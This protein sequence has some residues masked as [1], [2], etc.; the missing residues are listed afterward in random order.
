MEKCP[1]DKAWDSLVR[2]CVAKNIGSEPKPQPKPRE[3]PIVT[4]VDPRLSSTPAPILEASPLMV[5]GPA[6]WI[7]VVLAIVGSVLALAIWFVIFR[8]QK[9][10]SCTPA[11]GVELLPTTEPPVK[12]HPERN[13]RA[14][15]LQDE[16][17]APSPC[18]LHMGAQTGSK[19]EEGFTTRGG[20]EGGGDLQTCS[21]PL[22]ATE[23]GGTA[24]VTTKTV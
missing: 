16:E 20:P 14:E 22:P 8:Q 5:L 15:P 13:G 23:L 6:L 24:L 3:A 1:D 4:T 9:R 17:G 21:F 11:S 2:L 7:S 10:R 12:I 19:R 18:Q